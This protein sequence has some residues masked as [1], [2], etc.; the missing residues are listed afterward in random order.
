[1]DYALWFITL[2]QAQM[3][4]IKRAYKVLTAAGVSGDDAIRYLYD[5]AHGQV[6]SKRWTA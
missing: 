4:R 5:A 3:R 2:N 1:M 6:P